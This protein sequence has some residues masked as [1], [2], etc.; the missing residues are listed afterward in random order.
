[1]PE[2]TTQDATRTRKVK[3]II[4]TVEPIVEKSE[5]G[6][7]MTPLEYVRQLADE[8][9]PL[10]K[11]YIYRVDPKTT[12]SY[13]DLVSD[14]VDEQILE[15]R[16]GG[17]ILA[18][19][20]QHKTADGLKEGY[21]SRIEVLSEPKYTK[22][23]LFANPSLAPA[24]AATP[25]S[26]GGISEAMLSRLIDKLL[27][28]KLTAQTANSSAIEATVNMMKSAS[29][30]AIDVIA[31]QVPKPD[32]AGG[33][34]RETLALLK[35]LGVLGGAQQSGKNSILET[36]AVLKE[37]GVVGAKSE[38]KSLAEQLKDFQALKEFL[39]GDDSGGKGSG[40][41][42]I[43]DV[44][45]AIADKGPQM[46]DKVMFMANENIRRKQ[47]AAARQGIAATE[48]LPPAVATERPVEVVEPEN[49]APAATTGVDPDEPFK[50][51]V[52]KRIQEN[53]DPLIVLNLIEAWNPQVAAM[54]H[55]FNREAVRSF[56][57][58]DSI[59]K[60]ALNA[61]E[62]EKWF[63]AFYELIEED[64]RD[65]DEGAEPGSKRVQ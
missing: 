49:A 52:V 60:E 27:E 43:Y 16:Y 24:P 18:V 41:T 61:P 63:A 47:A 22:R 54:L 23:E 2:L 25:A 65:V 42:N 59:L 35:E 34:I 53:A 8:Q 14:R 26:S 50:K 62:F 58:A 1:M 46:L 56:I 38:T 17:K 10:C 30:R 12:G 51:L 32:S 31:A 57:Q 40:R 37:L 55:A 33:G 9:L 45:S 19:K 6:L 4:D 44:L 3:T 13:I 11:L 15:E 48:A 7:G 20:L 21:Q 28:E 29:D 64:N 36:I 5:T 39:G